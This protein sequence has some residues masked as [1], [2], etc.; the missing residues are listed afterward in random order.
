M[1]AVIVFMFTYGSKSTDEMIWMWVS[2]AVVLVVTIFN[3]IKYGLKDGALAS[4]AELVFSIS[5][6]FLLTCI[7]VS[8][9]QKANIR[10]A[11]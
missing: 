6:A 3:S 10:I 8:R 5:A 11:L 2:I 4:L 1:V 7:L 9:N